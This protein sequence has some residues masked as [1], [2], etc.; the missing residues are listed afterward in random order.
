MLD[1]IHK[2]MIPCERASELSS[3]EMDENLPFWQRFVLKTHRMMCSLCRRLKK[4]LLAIRHGVRALFSESL[5]LESSDT[6]G[7]SE[8]TRKLLKEKITGKLA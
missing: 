5:L 8:E 2:I 4:Q 1:F 3:L 7:L 6:P